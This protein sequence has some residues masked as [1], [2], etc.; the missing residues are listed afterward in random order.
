MFRKEYFFWDYNKGGDNWSNK[1]SIR[2][3]SINCMHVYRNK[4]CCDIRKIEN[5]LIDNYVTECFFSIILCI[6]S[7]VTNKPKMAV[8][9]LIL[10]YCTLYECHTCHL[11]P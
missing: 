8:Y 11:N 6:I 7:L 2:F 3:N 4:T 9:Y 10:Y 1:I 5:R